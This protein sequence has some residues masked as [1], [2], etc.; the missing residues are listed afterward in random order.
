MEFMAVTLAFHHS[1]HIETKASFANDIR[2]WAL[3]K[4]RVRQQGM[5]RLALPNHCTV[6]HGFV[7]IITFATILA[8]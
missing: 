6:N 7:P 2:L 8:F 1:C 5:I 4:V 3:L